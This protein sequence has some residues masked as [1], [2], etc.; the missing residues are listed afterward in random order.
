MVECEYK[1]RCITDLANIPQVYRE[2]IAKQIFEDIPKAD[3]ILDCGLDL[4]PIKSHPGYYRIRGM[5]RIG[6]KINPG[7]V[8]FYRITNREGIYSVF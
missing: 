1:K 4:N 2:K 8:I 3:N 6:I 7:K 5:Y